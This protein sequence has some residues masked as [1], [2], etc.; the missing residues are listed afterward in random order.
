MY[1][2]C[3]AVK[4][5]SL[6]DLAGLTIPSKMNTHFMCS[7]YR[8]TFRDLFKTCTGKNVK[9]N[10]VCSR[11]IIRAPLVNFKCWIDDCIFTLW[12]AVQLWKELWTLSVDYYGLLSEKKQRGKVGCIVFLFVSK[13]KKK[14]FPMWL[15]G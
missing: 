9:K 5:Q 2:F 4:K 13:R 11:F 7:V 1:S 15:S 3:E 8:S 10:P 6:L 14:Q 12:N